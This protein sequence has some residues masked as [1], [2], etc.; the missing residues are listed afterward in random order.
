MMNTRKQKRIGLFL[1][2]LMGILSFSSAV[3]TAE[4]TSGQYIPGT[5][6]ALA[7]GFGGDVS[8]EVTVDENEILSVSVVGEHETPSV[9]GRA[10]EQLPDAIIAANSAA[11][12]SVS[13][14]TITS[15]AILSATRTALQEASAQQETA[16]AMK[17]GKYAGIGSGYS[18]DVVVTVTLSENAI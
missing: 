2:M 1:A 9:G 15:T 4:E 10:L 3:A 11:V 13:G 6:T 8:V 12:D 17:P 18:D 7:K 14:A 5:Y 16:S